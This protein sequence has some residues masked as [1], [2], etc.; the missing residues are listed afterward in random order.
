MFLFLFAMLSVVVQW[1]APSRIPFFLVNVTTH[2]HLATHHDCFKAILS[3]QIISSDA[4]HHILSNSSSK[5]GF[6]I[7]LLLLMLLWQAVKTR[8]FSLKIHEKQP[9]RFCHQASG[10]WA[11]V[12]KQESMY[13]G[14]EVLAFRWPA[15]HRHDRDMHTKSLCTGGSRSNIIV[16]TVPECGM[17]CSGPHLLFR[18]P[19]FTSVF[20]GAALGRRALAKG[21]GEGRR[22]IMCFSL[23][24]KSLP[25]GRYFGVVAW[26]DLL[27][28]RHSCDSQPTLQAYH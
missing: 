17:Y 25:E 22:I 20:R 10:I 28:P 18:L 6:E 19:P 26:S 5:C 4:Y 24:F 9:I 3:F 15:D 27:A 7:I 2:P 23:P 21:L 13:I 1:C 16:F 14:E 12:P 11:V 8:H